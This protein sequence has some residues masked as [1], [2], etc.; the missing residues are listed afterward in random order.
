MAGLAQSYDTL[1][2]LRNT[3]KWKLEQQ[4]SL[5]MEKRYFHRIRTTII[6]EG[7]TWKGRIKGFKRNKDKF[8]LFI[9][10]PQDSNFIW[11][12]YFILVTV[13]VWGSVLD[14]DKGKCLLHVCEKDILQGTCWKK[15]YKSRDF[16]LFF[17]FRILIGIFLKR[18]KFAYNKYLNI[19]KFRTM[20]LDGPVLK[21]CISK[22]RSIYVP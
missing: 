6:L 4:E 7:N 20:H 16:I 3:D 18:E 2:S 19:P 22:W 10:K 17:F 12:N 9:W 5:F 1:K 14:T 21:G 11:K 8:C 15:Q 13:D